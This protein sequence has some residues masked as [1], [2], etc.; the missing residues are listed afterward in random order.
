[1][2][3]PVT[4]DEVRACI[5]SLHT[6]IPK[7]GL[8]ERNIDQTV[9]IYREALESYDGEAVRGAAKMLIS[10]AEKFPSPSLWRET[11]AT[12]C[13]HNRIVLERQPETDSEGNDIVCRVC[14]SVPRW[15]ILRGGDPNR[16]IRDETGTA[17]APGEIFRRIAP[18]DPS[19]HHTPHGIAPTPE[20][21][22]RWENSTP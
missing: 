9:R 13:K 12:W 16:V 6:A 5:E 20:N 4:L 17:L 22:L 10:T 1:M 21:F 15:A 11:C 7:F 14:R 2:R 19:R 18:C 3:V 8:S